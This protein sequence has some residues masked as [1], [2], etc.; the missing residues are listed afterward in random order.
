V[1]KVVSTRNALEELAR[2]V[3]QEP[4][5]VPKVLAR[6]RI[7]LRGTAR[8]YVVP[9]LQEL[10]FNS[11]DVPAFV[12]DYAIGFVESLPTDEAG[13]VDSVWAELSDALAYREFLDDDSVPASIRRAITAGPLERFDA[14]LE[15]ACAG[16]EAF[17][18]LDRQ[19]IA[20]A[21]THPV[22]HH[23]MVE[24]WRTLEPNLVVEHD[25]DDAQIS[26]AAATQ[27]APPVSGTAVVFLAL[28]VTASTFLAGLIHITLGVMVFFIGLGVGGWYLMRQGEEDVRNPNARL[29]ARNINLDRAR[30]TMNRDFQFIE[31]AAKH[32]LTLYRMTNREIALARESVTSNTMAQFVAAGTRLAWRVGLILPEMEPRNEA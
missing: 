23:R 12:L 14:F 15:L 20:L 2:A 6:H 5:Q 4:A 1:D 13:L 8:E 11:T 16:A 3:R 27:A 7:R 29:A 17:N 25:L 31:F 26:P 18:A 30:A 10:G 19:L 24:N 22:A 9:L 21:H 28:G 32:K